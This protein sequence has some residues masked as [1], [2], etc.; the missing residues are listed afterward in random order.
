MSPEAKSM[1]G[2]RDNTAQTVRMIALILTIMIS[3]AMLGKLLVGIE[4]RMMR[5]EYSIKTVVEKQWTVGAMDRYGSQLV[6]DNPDLHIRVPDV[7]QIHR[8]VIAR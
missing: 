2:N 3:T 7:R 1:N 4:R 5:V 8:D 6:A